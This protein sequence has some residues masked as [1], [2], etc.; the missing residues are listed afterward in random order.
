MTPQVVLGDATWRK[1]HEHSEA[2]AAGTRASGA[3][4]GALLDTGASPD[5]HQLLTLLLR[6]KHPCIF[7]ESEV[8]GDGSDW[9]QEELSILGDLSIALDVT[10]FDDGAHRNPVPHGTPFPATLVFTPGALLRN[11][12]GGATVDLAE[13]TVDGELDTTRFRRLYERR[14]LPVFRFIHA[15][16]AARG[17]HAVVTAP[18]LGC[19][20]F[21]G[22]FRGRLGSELA[23]ALEEIL[24]AG[25]P[26]LDR[27][28]LVRF[29]PYDEC[30]DHGVS[31]DATSFRVRPL[32]ST[33]YPRAQLCGVAAYQEPGDDLSGCDLFSIV[34]WDHVSWPGNDFFRGARVTDDGVKAAATSAMCSLT[35]VEGHYDRVTN[36]YLPPPEY[37][38]WEAV[39]TDNSLTLT[40]RL[41]LPH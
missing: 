28:R 19:G 22:P 40:D 31:L 26:E 32:L 37:R 14:L 23:A 12:R 34:A 13:V 8:A 30:A 6:S 1:L 16:A 36:R 7:A 5:S 29:D 3:R 38:D 39:V 25:A 17:T 9:T 18:G 4:V 20:Q 24:E 2:L 27:L 41:I 10:V 15:T 21:A 35:G 11:D 33:A